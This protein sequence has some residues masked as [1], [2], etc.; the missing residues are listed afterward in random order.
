MGNLLEVKN[1]AVSFKTYGGEVQAV[2][3]VSFTVKP[4][5]TVAIVGESGSGKSVTATTL[6][7]LIPVPPGEI[8]GGEILFNGVDLTRLTDRQMENYRGAEMGIVFQDPGTSLNPTM[9]IGRQIGESFLYREKISKK[10]VRK[11][12]LD[13]LD[14]V[15]IPQGEVRI[16]QYPHQFS[17]GMKQRVMLAMALAGR[18]KLLIADEPTTA[19][20]VTIQA[21]IIDLLRHLKEQLQMGLLL[22]THDFGVADQLADQVLVMYAGRIMEAGRKE[23]IFDHAQH[24]YTRGLLKSR[25]Q[26]NPEDGERLFIIPG[27]PPNLF[28][29]PPGC[30]FAS[31]CPDVMK[32]C[33]QTAPHEVH[34]RVTKGAEHRVACWQYH[35]Q[36][37]RDQSRDGGGE[38][39]ES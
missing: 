6:M 15:G 21:Q 29:P 23:D 25:P 22:I 2:R 19:L 10:A 3:G 33:V 14:L 13:L 20:D 27:Q 24:P 8:K 32:V 31:R 4:G 38:N 36:S 35:P 30:P 9:K 39:H 28:L 37:K 7:G 18:P 16:D 26:I 11:K 1:L 12:V 5:E 34:L 17:G